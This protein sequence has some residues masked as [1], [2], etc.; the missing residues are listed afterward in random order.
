MLIFFYSG[1]MC[2]FMH[3]SAEKHKVWNCTSGVKT[4]FCLRKRALHS[5]NCSMEKAVSKLT[6]R[7]W[8]CV[9]AAVQLHNSWRK[10]SIQSPNWSGNS[11]ASYGSRTSVNLAN[12]DLLISQREQFP[13]FSWSED[14]FLITRK[15][16]YNQIT[17]T[18][19]ELY[20]TDKRGK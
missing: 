13:D 17:I 1:L 18:E 2:Y 6:I 4:L 20:M 16:I 11:A 3:L 10:S 15:A 7:E 5:S 9:S 19:A 14:Y 8:T 12:K